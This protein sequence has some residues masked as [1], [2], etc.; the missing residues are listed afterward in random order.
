MSGPRIEITVSPKGETQTRVFGLQGESCKVAS[1]PYEQLYGGIISTE[2]T[3]EAYEDPHEIEID[4][5]QG[6]N[7]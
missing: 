5:Q 7:E 2:A 1:A 4:V 3:S 6:G